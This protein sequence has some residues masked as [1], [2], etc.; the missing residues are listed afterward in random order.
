VF[1]L[2]NAQGLAEA[3]GRSWILTGD[4]TSFMRD[5]DQIEKVT[6][7]DVKRVI[8]QYMSPDHATVVII[9]PKGAPAQPPAATRPTPKPPATAPKPASKAPKAA[10]TATPKQPA[11]SQPTTPAE[12]NK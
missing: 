1:S 7:A 4:G 12:K 10:P 6:V 9:P 2:E 11:P 3:I 8:K 5:V